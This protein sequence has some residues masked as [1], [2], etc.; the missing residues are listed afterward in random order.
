MLPM[1]AL[2]SI[3]MGH[4]VLDN[5]AGLDDCDFHDELRTVISIMPMIFFVTTTSF[6]A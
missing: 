3:I 2:M 6:I 4:D 5:N 1:V